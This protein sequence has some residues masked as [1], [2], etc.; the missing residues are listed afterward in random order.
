MSG[1]WQKRS[2][3]SEA[4]GTDEFVHPIIYP[5]PQLVAA[6]STESDG[7]SEADMNSMTPYREDDAEADASDGSACAAVDLADFCAEAFAVVS[8]WLMDTGYN[9]G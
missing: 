5:E 4:P 6:G 7:D 8:L 1:M 2:S 9:G 3:H